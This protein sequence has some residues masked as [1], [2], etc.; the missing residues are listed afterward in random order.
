[1]RAEATIDSRLLVITL[2]NIGDL[3]LTT[4]V[5]E[6]LAAYFPGLLVDVLGDARSIE[7]LRAAPYVGE[8][9]VRDKR[10]GWLSQWQLLRRLRRRRYELIVDLRTPFLPWLLRA[11]QR[12]TN[13]TRTSVERHAVLDH[14]AVIRSLVQRDQPPPCR[15]YVAADAVAVANR[16]TCVLPGTRWL[17]IAPGANWAGKKWPKE[18]F[19]DLLILARP[20]IDAVIVLGSAADTA[21]C[22]PLREAG[23]PMLETAGATSLTVAAALLAR[24]CLFVGND[25]GLGHVA[26]ALGVPSLTLFGPGRPAR[27]RPW[28]EQAR[29]LLAPEAKLALLEPGVVL[30]E[31]V[32]ALA[33]APEAPH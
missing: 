17:A 26:A 18:Y 33:A 28:G 22:A 32:A 7:L 3:V 31:M 27:Y 19:R 1:M 11:R 5:L 24:A 15:L 14:Y 29:V 6:A 8:L 23:L 16:M 25:S 10:A 4:P 30:N 13:R 20:H 21:D 9:F 2:S 12:R